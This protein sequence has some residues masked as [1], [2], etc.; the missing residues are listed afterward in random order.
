MATPPP[1]RRTRSDSVLG[2]RD[3]IKVSQ[4]K[5]WA[6]PLGDLPYFAPQTPKSH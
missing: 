5:V 1:L 6:E 3:L 2:G 4:A